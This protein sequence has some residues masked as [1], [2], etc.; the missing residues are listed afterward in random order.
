MPLR[1]TKRA[2]NC[3]EPVVNRHRNLLNQQSFRLLLLTLTNVPV[4]FSSSSGRVGPQSQCHRFSVKKV[5]EVEVL[6]KKK[7]PGSS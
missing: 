3:N 4:L 7:S 5:V 6:K 2:I 1:K